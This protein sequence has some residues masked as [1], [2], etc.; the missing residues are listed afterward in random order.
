[1]CGHVQDLM[2]LSVTLQRCTYGSEHIVY[3]AG[4]HSTRITIYR[5]ML[6]AA[7]DYGAERV[8]QLNIL[9]LFHV[10]SHPPERL[11]NVCIWALSN[12]RG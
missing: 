11:N 2:D 7:R 10:E 9:R 3:V 6:L 12:G 1:M 5:Y 4:K 8:L